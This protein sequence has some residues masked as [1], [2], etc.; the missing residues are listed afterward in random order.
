MAM[1]L[2][3][4]GYLA[5]DHARLLS[6]GVLSVDMSHYRSRRAEQRSAWVGVAH[7]LG[8][9]TTGS[10]YARVVIRCG[11]W[12][13]SPDYKSTNYTPS[14]ALLSEN[15]THG[16]V[17]CTDVPEN[18]GR[19]KGPSLGVIA[20]F[21]H[22][23]HPSQPRSRFV[24]T[25]DD[26]A[27]LHLAPF[28]LL[29]VLR[30]LPFSR[31]A[32]PGCRGASCDDEFVYTG[33]IHGWSIN[34]TAFLFH[35]FGWNGGPG[36][37][38]PYPFATGMFMCVS[39]ALAKEVVAATAPDELAKVYGLSPRHKLF[40]HDP[41][42]GQ[43]IY[44]L[45]PSG[46]SLPRIHVFNIDA[47]ALDTDGFR[48]PP[49]LLLWHNRHKAGCRVQCLGDFY[50]RYACGARPRQYSWGAPEER[51]RR[52]INATRYVMWD[53]IFANTTD[54]PHKMPSPGEALLV[55][56]AARTDLGCQR[57]VDLRNLK[58][59]ASL[60]LTKCQAC[61][62]AVQQA[63]VQ[64]AKV[65]DANKRAAIAQAKAEQANTPRSGAPAPG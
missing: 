30:A 51:G 2:A 20:W 45:V 42:L 3:P 8:Q 1:A 65:A 62:D 34:H 27:F 40:F 11:T 33:P 57:L 14:A 31:D 5:P 25:A 7:S 59:V 56:E 23:T 46:Q 61:F 21:A 55:G 47:W 4:T 64:Q 29:D 52:R 9:L 28:G 43:A 6:V 35:S 16:D 26:D 63:K 39:H 17:L 32:P 13:M 15:A 54:R 19:L 10:V 18:A 44:R 41:F 48:V 50:E 24:A 38:G 12:A 22:V 37:D 60:N 36:L 49:S 58:T 53:P